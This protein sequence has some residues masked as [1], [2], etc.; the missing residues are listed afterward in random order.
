MVDLHAANTAATRAVHG[1]CCPAATRGNY[2]YTRA[3]TNDPARSHGIDLYVNG[4]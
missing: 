1:S 4:V 2:L 3:V